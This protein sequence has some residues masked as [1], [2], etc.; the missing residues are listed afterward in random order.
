MG[1]PVAAAWE[2]LDYLVAG[3]Q[4]GHL[5]CYSDS[6]QEHFTRR[7]VVNN[8]DLLGPLIEHLG[9]L[10]WVLFVTTECTEI[11]EALRTWVD[12]PRMSLDPK[13]ASGMRPTVTDVQKHVDEFFWRVRARAKA[14]VSGA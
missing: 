3:A 12:I 1:S 2:K 14:P 4:K 11:F 5:V 10:A 9:S 13:I 6:K 7:D 8:A